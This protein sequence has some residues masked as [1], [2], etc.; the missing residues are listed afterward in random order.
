M[1]QYRKNKYRIMVDE[2]KKKLQEQCRLVEKY[3]L[4][5][6]MVQ[7]GA[8]CSGIPVNIPDDA[9]R[10]IWKEADFEHVKNRVAELR[11]EGQAYLEQQSQR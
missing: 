7:I 9:D 8:I 6:E 2:L 3:E 10:K 5:V 1:R 11:I 4:I